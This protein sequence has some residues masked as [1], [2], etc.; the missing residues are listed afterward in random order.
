LYVV[1]STIFIHS[2][3]I[4]RTSPFFSKNYLTTFEEYLFLMSKGHS[5]GRFLAEGIKS[6][7]PIN[8]SILKLPEACLN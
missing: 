4:K 3:A 2:C 6:V 8:R 7:G 5:M 1:C